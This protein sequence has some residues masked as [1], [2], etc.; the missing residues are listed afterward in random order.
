MVAALVLWCEAMRA[1][2]HQSLRW[3]GQTAEVA[4]FCWR[5]K[6]WGSACRNLWWLLKYWLIRCW[7]CSGIGLF[8]FLLL[9]AA[10]TFGSNLPDE[11]ATILSIMEKSM[12][13][14]VL[15]LT[16]V[17][18]F[19]EQYLASLVLDS[20]LSAPWNQL[21]GT[22]FGAPV[23]FPFSFACDLL[24]WINLLAFGKHAIASSS[25]KKVAATKQ[26]P[27]FSDV[28]PSTL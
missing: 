26:T 11:Q 18:P 7:L 16:L 27:P 17:M 4:E 21:P 6:A 14:L 5:F 12:S 23:G 1:A 24:A 2:A 15:T 28:C 9:L 8:S 13:A 10:Y 25:R 20:T 22:L 3:A 19:Y